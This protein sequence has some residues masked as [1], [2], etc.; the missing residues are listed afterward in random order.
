MHDKS[1]STK[2]SSRQLE[3]KVSDLENELADCRKKY[4]VVE[5]QL[6]EKVQETEHLQQDL[7]RTKT[8]AAVQEQKLESDLELLRR[9]HGSATCSLKSTQGTRFVADEVRKQSEE[10]EML[11]T[12]HDALTLES[13][14]LQQDLAKAEV[15]ISKLKQNM[16]EVERHSFENEIILRREAKVQTDCVTKELDNVRQK[17]E[18]EKSRIAAKEQEWHSQVREIQLEK[19]RAEQRAHS[20]QKDIDSVQEL[21]GTTS[22]REVEIQETLE[23][24][25]QRHHSEEAV[26]K[27]HLREIEVDIEHQERSLEH[28][29]LDILKLQEELRISRRDHDTAEMKIQS[30]EDEIYVLQTNLNEEVGK[31]QGRLAEAREEAEHLRSQVNC[32]HEVATTRPKLT[33]T[34]GTG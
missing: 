20:L 2:G 30:L 1:L 25:T 16:E 12:R 4:A 24:E 21:K 34:S 19:E 22:A 10:K 11:Q 7:E 26:L 13:Q 32:S 17:L 23:S 14:T 27:Q 6:R 18:H 9:Q 33:L 15:Q 3:E 28:R 8:R 5:D 31:A 29:N